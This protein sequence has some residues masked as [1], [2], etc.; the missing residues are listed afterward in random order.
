MISVIDE[1]EA[2]GLVRRQRDPQDRRRYALRI[3]EAGVVA[4]ERMRESAG[5]ATGPSPLPSV[6]R[7]PGG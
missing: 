7:A 3:T 6:R 4:L 2:A 1:L 5:R